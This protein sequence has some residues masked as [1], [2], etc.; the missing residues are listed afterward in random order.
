VTKATCLQFV[1]LLASCALLRAQ[2]P[3]SSGVSIQTWQNDTART[4]IY[5]AI[6]G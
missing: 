2:D 3:G 6:P 5:T 1:F 4:E